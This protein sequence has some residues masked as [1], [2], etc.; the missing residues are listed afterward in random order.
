MKWMS[1]LMVMLLIY[2]DGVSQ[3]DPV[4]KDGL[5]IG[6]YDVV[7]YFETG[8]AEKGNAKFQSVYEGVTYYF[9]S[10][11]RQKLF[12]ANPAKYVP[13]YNG[14]CALAVSYGKKVSI[15]PET[16]KV[17]NDKLYLFYNGKTSRGKINSLDT[18]NKSEDRLLKKANTLWPE[19]K[20]LKYKAGSGL[21]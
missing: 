13:Q 15:D 14:Y 2:M 4:D 17:M 18:W 8:K 11:E 9:T 1:L 10:A 3:V 21:E 20:N 16:F 12:D 6:G 19:V 7:A 5:A